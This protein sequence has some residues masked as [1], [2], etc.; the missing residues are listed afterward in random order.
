MRFSILIPAFKS[1]FLKECVDSIL[2]QTYNDFEVI[3]V[4]DASPEDL[5]SVVKLYGDARI[6]YHRNEVGFGASNVV[7][8]WNRC[9]EYAQGDYIICMGDDDMLTP[10]AL[11]EYDKLIGKYPGLG[12]YHGLTE[13]IDE[14]GELVAMQESRPE[15]ESVFSL[16]WHR[17]TTRCHQ[18]I[19]D[20]CFDAEKLCRNGGFYYLPLAWG[21]DDISAVMAARES[22]VANTNA[23]CFLYRKNCQTISMGGGTQ[24]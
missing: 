23:L 20:W 8:N 3:I 10:N 7:G 11:E 9:L 13:L 24:A 19:G 16:I 1:R 21:S 22:G 14:K 12:V 6:H 17:W 2:A 4:D 5:Y 18:Y 15:F